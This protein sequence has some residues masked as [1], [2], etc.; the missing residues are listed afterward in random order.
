ML[1][2][3]AHGSKHKIWFASNSGPDLSDAAARQLYLDEVALLKRLLVAN[4]TGTQLLLAHHAASLPPDAGALSAL[5]AHAAPAPP[6]RRVDPRTLLPVAPP[7]P[8][9]TPDIADDDP[10]W[11]AAADAASALADEHERDKAAAAARRRAAADAAQ[12][13]RGAFAGLAPDFK[14]AC[15]SHAIVDGRFVCMEATTPAKVRD[16][17]PARCAPPPPPRLG[18]PRPRYDPPTMIPEQPLLPPRGHHS[19]A[20][21]LD[22]LRDLTTNMKVSPPRMRTADRAAGL[23]QFEDEPRPGTADTADTAP[24]APKRDLEFSSPKRNKAK[25]SIGAADGSRK[26]QFKKSPKK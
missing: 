12:R 4:P 1:L 23:A 2:I 18:P 6:P 11:L 3:N 7:A 9:P 26:P 19:R 8:P 5:A 17:P 15:H 14:P 20:V 25:A 10:L 24:V 22:A 13:E 16:A 21:E